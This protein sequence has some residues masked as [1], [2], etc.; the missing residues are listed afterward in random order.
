MKKAFIILACSLFLNTGVALAQC[1]GF[2]QRGVEII[3]VL[4]NPQLAQGTDDQRRQLT[5]TFIEQLVF[6]FPNAGYVWKS[7][8]P[9]RPPSKD[10]I[11]ILV[12]GRLC[13][14]DWQ[15]GTSRMRSVVAGQPGD[16]ITG[17]NPITVPGVNHL[18]SLPPGP[19]N[20]TPTPNPVPVPAPAAVDLSQVYLKLDNLYAQAERIFAAQEAEVQARDQ[21]LAVIDAKVQAHIDETHSFIS[22]VGGFFT[23]GKT[24]A[25]IVAGVGTFLGTQAAK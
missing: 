21:Q 1:P 9:G 14:W 23:D 16:D 13:N 5:R 19:P 2:P 25:A 22:K 8:D 15:N 18:A 17:Q 10:S 4:Y 12:G 6:E 24:I 7:A 11:S 3:D 20:P